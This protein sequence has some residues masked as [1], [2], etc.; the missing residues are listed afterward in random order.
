MVIH[1]SSVVIWSSCAEI[2]VVE[3][4]LRRKSKI[5]VQTFP[6]DVK[7]LESFAGRG[8]ILTF[9]RTE[10]DHHSSNSTFLGLSPRHLLC[11]LKNN[12]TQLLTL[13]LAPS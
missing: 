4:N 1:D 13:H 8:T 11:L 5:Y 9:T 10:M 6:G 3:S 12:I 2:G 7:R